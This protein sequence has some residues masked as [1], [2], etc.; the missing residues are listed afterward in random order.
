MKK[1]FMSLRELFFWHLFHIVVCILIF[2][3]FFIRLQNIHDPLLNAH[4]FRQTQTATVAKNF[5]FDGIDI[6]HPRIDIAGIGKE[7]NLILE[8]PFYQAQVA[9]L[10]RTIGYS[11]S[12]G[13]IVSIIWALAGGYILAVFVKEISRN[14]II[15]LSSMIFYF[16]APLNIFYQQAF[17]IESTVV[18]L[19]ILSIYSWYHFNKHFNW[20]WGIIFLLSCVLAFL[21][22][23]VYAPFLLLALVSLLLSLHGRKIV[24]NVRFII[25]LIIALILVFMWQKY[26]DSA[27]TINGNPYFTSTSRGQQLWNFGTLAD[28]FIWENW[29]SRFLIVTY[30]VT[31]LLLFPLIMG[32]YYLIYKK[33]KGHKI[34]LGWFLSMIIYFLVLF[35]IQSH[36]Y[37]FM[38]VIPI[39]SI[40]ASY[41]LVY[42]SNILF[43][44]MGKRRYRVFSSIFVILFL[45]LYGAKS[46]LNS[47]AYFRIDW[48]M[49]NGIGIINSGL[50][51]KGYV[52]FLLPEYDWNSVYTYYTGRKGIA[53]G[54]KDVHKEE[55]D[56]YKGQGY[57]YVVVEYN[58]HLP[59]LNKQLAD[60]L[61][62]LQMAVNY[63]DHAV[64]KL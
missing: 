60:Y 58:S 31:K 33:D 49:Q 25:P 18:T 4:Y 46:L 55:L 35:R 39:L 12:L 17:M 44:W 30:G 15:A 37:Y 32:L 53:A 20:K 59:R 5:Y 56:I 6:L 24:R 48:N 45:G 34:W 22:K 2:I 27:N 1:Y 21:Q 61:S 50:R 3:T 54:F 64:Y 51:E 42:F 36:E 57:T 62:T 41:G 10:A 7:Q 8:F 9:Y 38:I 47:T 23:T 40:I 11:D 26:V 16:F 13:R 63:K 43:S 14:A 19:H 28:R 29:K 52:L